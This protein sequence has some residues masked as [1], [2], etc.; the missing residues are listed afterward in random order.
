MR[1]PLRALVFD[2]D[3]TLVDT[4]DAVPSAFIESIAARGGRRHT[5]DEVIRAYSLGPP[6]T[7]LAHLLGRPCDDADLEA[8]YECLRQRAGLIER[9]PGI[10][11]TLHA[12]AGR[13]RLGVFSGASE[14]SCSIILGATGLLPRFDAVVGG[15]Q[16]RRPKPDPAGILE[17]C[18]RLGVRASEVA[19]VGDTSH[20]CEAARRAGTLAVAAAW[21]HL[22]DER[23]TADLVARRPAD[24]LELL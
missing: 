8:Y 23:I 15:D 22:Y 10:V 7:L 5:A 9:Y 20:D 16:V 21:G 17:A 6:K 24:L 1:N 13:A 3:G 4:S 2:M 19:Y 11:E 14:D 12:L 18:S